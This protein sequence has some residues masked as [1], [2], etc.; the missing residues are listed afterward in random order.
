MTSYNYRQEADNYLV[1]LAA[2]MVNFQLWY[3]ICAVCVC[4]PVSMCV[5]YFFNWLLS[6]CNLSCKFIFQ[7]THLSKEKSHS[8]Q[9]KC[10]GI[11]FA[12]ISCSPVDR[13]ASPSLDFSV[14]KSDLSV[15]YICGPP[16][17]FAFVEMCARTDVMTGCREKYVVHYKEICEKCLRSNYI[18]TPKN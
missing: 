3:Q 9:L 17:Q 13:A 10:V 15:V 18:T 16:S 8:L 7:K 2:T 6:V 5:H 12:W 4:A 11:Y 14:A 1:I